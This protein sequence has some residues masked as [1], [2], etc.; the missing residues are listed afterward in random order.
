MIGERIYFKIFKRFGRLIFKSFYYC[1]LVSHYPRPTLPPCAPVSDT[2]TPYCA[3]SYQTPTTPYCAHPTQTP[4]GPTV[5][6]PLRHLQALLCTPHSDTYRPYC[7]HPY[8]TPAGPTVYTP[9][10]HLHTVQCIPLSDTCTPYC[11]HPIRHLHS[12][13]CTLY[14]NTPHSHPSSL[15]VLECPEVFTSLTVGYISLLSDC[16]RPY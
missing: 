4:T 9:I 11:V 10:K 14:C 6:T 2:Y 3:H 8:Q 12:L 16:V 7:V 5:H 15:V 1:S 13:L